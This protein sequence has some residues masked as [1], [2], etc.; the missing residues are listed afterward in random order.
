MDKNIHA[1]HRERQLEKFRRV[2]LDAFTDVEVLELLLYFG[3]PFKDTNPLAHALLDRFGSVEKVL[4]A[5]ISQLQAVPGIGPHAATLL[6]LEEQ[7]FRRYMI[8]R[9][10]TLKDMSN[11]AKAGEVVTAYLSGKRI[12]VLYLFSM[13]VHWQL[14]DVKEVQSGTIDREPIYL[15]EIVS[16]ALAA[17]AYYVIVAHNH[18]SGNLRPS[19]DD[20]ESTVAIKRALESVGIRVIDHFI[21]ADGKYTSMKAMGILG[22][23]DC[24]DQTICME[25]NG[26]KKP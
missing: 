22:N 21:V 24:A 3:I 23:D 1:G 20:V 25:K 16:A 7:L 11:T 6:R 26:G 13:D 15:R 10:R 9:V 17:S 5:D 4:Q 18:P 2:G 12:E 8:D 14:I 19:R